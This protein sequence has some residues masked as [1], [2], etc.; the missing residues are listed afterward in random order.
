M[1]LLKILAFTVMLSLLSTK[2]SFSNAYV[3]LVKRQES[4]EKMYIS[5]R[6]FLYNKLN[7]FIYKSQWLLQKKK[8]KKEAK[9]WSQAAI[10]GH[11][12]IYKN[13]Y[14]LKHSNKWDKKIAKESFEVFKKNKLQYS[15]KSQ[16]LIG[17]KCNSLRDTIRKLYIGNKETNKIAVDK[18]FKRLKH[19]IVKI[20]EIVRKMKD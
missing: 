17:K 5:C 7:F 8:D 20:K 12:N 16:K 10:L 14:N 6:P 13:F 3:D 2:Y 15:N 1:Y 18:A 11:L 19:S 9:K 4:I